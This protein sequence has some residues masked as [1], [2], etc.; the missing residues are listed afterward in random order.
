M[1]NNHSK[2]ST[3]TASEPTS[4]VSKPLA[5]LCRHGPLCGVICHIL[6]LTT[7][8]RRNLTIHPPF[9]PTV[10]N[11]PAYSEETWKSFHLAQGASSIDSSDCTYHVSCRAARCKLPNVDQATARRDPA[12]DAEAFL[13]T[14][15]NVDSGC[16]DNGCLGM[17]V[18]PVFADASG[19]DGRLGYVEVG[20]EVVVGERGEHVYVKA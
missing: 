9:L 14:H 6:P 16:P 5:Y 11:T 20:M 12:V 4:S 15:R 3:P 1:H 10:S 7:C 17:M 19:A 8:G 2:I 18:T 13:R